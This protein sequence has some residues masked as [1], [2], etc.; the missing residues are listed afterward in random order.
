MYVDDKEQC[1]RGK[2]KTCIPVLYCSLCGI[3]DDEVHLRR[4]SAH[5]DDIAVVLG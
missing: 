1:T 2:I 3:A 5:H 4:F